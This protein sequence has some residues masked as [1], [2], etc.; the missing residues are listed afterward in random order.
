[1]SHTKAIRH[2]I[3]MTQGS[4]LLKIFRFAVPL[5]F[6]SILQLLFNAADMIIVGRFAENG[7]RAL[8]A[9]GSTTS[10]INL[11][12]NLFSGM[13]V[14][15]TVIVARYFGQRSDKDISESVHTAVAIA[16]TA[17]I[18]VSTIG[19]VFTESLLVL[20]NTPTE[21][22]PFAT[23]YMRIY[24]GG[25]FFMMVYTYCSAVLRATG[26]TKRPLVF[27]T[28]AGILN[29]ILNVLFVV[30]FK[31]NVEGVA[32]AT[33]ISQALS[34]FLVVLCLKKE[35]SAIKLKFRKVRF[36][37]GK[38]STILKIGIPAGVQ[39]SLFSV[40]NMVIQSAVNGFGEYAMAGVSAATNID[41][42]VYAAMDSVHQGTVSFVAQ[43]I[44]AG[45]D[46]RI[47]KSVPLTQ[48]AV[49]FT[50]LILGLLGVIFSKEIISIFTDDVQAIAYGVER[51][52][53]VSGTYFICGMMGTIS[54]YPIGAG[55][56]LIPT[57]INL[58]N[59]C[60]FRVIYVLTLFKNPIFHTM[61]GLYLCYP[62]S[63]MLCLL[64]L[65]VLYLCT[66][67]TINAQCKESRMK[68]RREGYGK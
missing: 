4:I 10:I 14:G 54:S 33:V 45:K 29:V 67:S 65:F 59:V 6:A 25:M 49:F 17:G 16:I 24:F 44:G 38:T 53:M 66:V 28:L 18:I 7:E 31:M 1:M 36:Y 23:V 37:K 12:V 62:A 30:V 40:S 63:W 46:E 60:G 8:A 35:D 27:L 50:G 11:F 20:L 34:A 15:V 43:N 56:T 2:S 61:K 68:L 64:C 39:S 9:V 22:L 32:I 55:K 21:V 41:N 58:V 13:S 52:G 57:V 42:I 19:I 48:L 26:D 3:D 51:V 5:A 47:H